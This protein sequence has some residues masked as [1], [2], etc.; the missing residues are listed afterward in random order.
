MKKPLPTPMA[1]AIRAFFGD[2]LPRV[3]GMSAHTIRSYRDS[4]ILLLRFVAF[5]RRREP[6]M[7]DFD[8]ISSD[9]VL[10]IPGPS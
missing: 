1:R 9:D 7:L 2:H 10:G 4:L 8:D 5:C 3:R 6:V